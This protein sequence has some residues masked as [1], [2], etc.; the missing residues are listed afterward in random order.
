MLSA[1][2]RICERER[3]DADTDRRRIVEFDV[4][5]RRN[6]VVLHGAQLVERGDKL[7]QLGVGRLRDSADER[8]H[9]DDDQQ[10]HAAADAGA[11][12][13]LRMLRVEV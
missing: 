10:T 11:P 4:K 8:A 7:Q 9:N 2:A 5:R 12:H 13:A 1:S 6:G 3:I